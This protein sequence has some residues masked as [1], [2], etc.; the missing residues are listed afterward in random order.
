M[1]LN[2]RKPQLARRLGAPDVTPLATVLAAGGDW[3]SG[4]ASVPDEQGLR[5]LAVGAQGPLGIPD[6]VAADLPEVLAAARERFDYVLI[7]APPLT[8]SGEALRVTSAVDAVVLVLRPG[9][10]R[11][12][13]LESVL[14][15]LQ[16][17][18][19]TPAGLLLVGG[20]VPGD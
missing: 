15:I 18:L 6:D 16:R 3:E 17:A 7:D 5:L 8:E 12:V 10:T 11:L 1:D 4:T 9:K 13:D 14:A 19:W 2:T 20:R